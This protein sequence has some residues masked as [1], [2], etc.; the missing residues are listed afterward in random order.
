MDSHS[1]A[2]HRA[3]LAAVTTLVAV[4][5]AVSM[6]FAGPVAVA[7]VPDDAPVAPQTTEQVVVP[8]TGRISGLAGAA[9]TR[10][11]TAAVD[12]AAAV[13][14]T[15][16]SPVHCPAPESE[17]VDS[18][19]FARSGGRRHK[20][21]DMMAPYGSPVIAPVSGTVRSS[22][23]ALGGLGFYLD[24]EAGNQYFGSHLA[25]LERTGWVEAGDRIGTVGTSGNAG[26]PHLHFEIAPGGGASTNPF[27]YALAWCTQDPDDPWAEVPLP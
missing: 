4:I 23:S 8:A 12:L 20:G 21:V 5:G 24:D 25:T 3:L 10:A 18:W 9:A 17:F 27:P 14:P 13:T 1:R 15:P 16:P 6:V 11:F 22:N 7:S 2:S 19:G 26:S